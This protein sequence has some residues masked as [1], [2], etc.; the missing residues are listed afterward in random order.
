P[1]EGERQD[2]VVLSRAVRVDVRLGEQAALR[3]AEFHVPRVLQDGD[4][5][6]GGAGVTIAA[7]D[8]CQCPGLVRRRLTHQHQRGLLG[9]HLGPGAETD[10]DRAWRY[11]LD[12][13]RQRRID[14]VFALGEGDA[15]EGLQIGHHIAERNPRNL[16]IASPVERAGPGG[17]VEA[18]QLGG[19]EV[20]VPVFVE[21][22]ADIQY[23]V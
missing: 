9:A 12:G 11:K 7:R 8:L 22:G 2:V 4:R 17:R 19:Q 18:R 15:F 23:V 14:G 3:I 6:P 5:R 1:Y 21:I 10:A 16:L 20:R 13:K